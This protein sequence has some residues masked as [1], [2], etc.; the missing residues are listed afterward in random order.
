MTGFLAAEVGVSIQ[1]DANHGILIMKFKIIDICFHV[2]DNGPVIY[3]V[4]TQEILRFL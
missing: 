1:H 2:Y 3:P 4:S